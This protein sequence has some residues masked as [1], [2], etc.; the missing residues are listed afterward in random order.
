MKNIILG[1]VTLDGDVEV[2]IDGTPL[3]PARSL[4]VYRHSP[5]GFQWGY[6]GFG[7]AQL[8][9]AILLQFVKEEV[10]VKYYQQFKLAHI[11]TQTNRETL[12]IELDVY[13]WIMQCEAGMI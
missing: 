6:A 13:N 5:D 4:K 9:L 7:P 3:S 12:R 8:A 10:A 2:F 11:A 1:Q